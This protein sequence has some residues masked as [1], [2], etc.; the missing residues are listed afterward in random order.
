MTSIQAVKA[1]LGFHL[2][3]CGTN[4]LYSKA[5]AVLTVLSNL[6]HVTTGSSRVSIGET[7]FLR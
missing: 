7:A 2:D 3:F 4:R 1:Y 6:Q 5:E